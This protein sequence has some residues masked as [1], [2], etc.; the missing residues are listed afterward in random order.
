MTNS[1]SPIFNSKP[2]LS[3]RLSLLVACATIALS[4]LVPT[5]MGVLASN[6]Q[7]VWPLWPGCAT[8]VTGLLLI[9]VKLW[10][11][12]IPPSFIG[13]AVFVVVR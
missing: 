9:P 5:L 6:P 1:I 3:F 13:F 2:Y 4:R 10:L 11:V 12:V 8:L 7:T